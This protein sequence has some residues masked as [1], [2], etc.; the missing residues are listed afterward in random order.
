V[1]LHGQSAMRVRIYAAWFAG[2]LAVGIVLFAVIGPRLPTICPTCLLFH[3]VQDGLYIE[4]IKVGGN[5]ISYDNSAFKR[6]PDDRNV[7]KTIS[8]AQSKVKQFFGAREVDPRVFVC[9]TERCYITFERHRGLS[10]AI[11]FGDK[12]IFVSPRGINVTILSHELTHSEL[13]HRLGVFMKLVPTWFDEGL[14]VYV[15]D[16]RRYIAAPDQKDR[17]LVHTNRAMPEMPSGWWDE[18]E[19]RKELY[20]EAAC[21]VSEWIAAHHGS[22]AVTKLIAAMHAGASFRQAFGARN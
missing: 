14:A 9:V 13:H 15:S 3:K 17:C 2:S 20:S 11:S 8:V 22:V 5:E 4:G 7:E 6:A 19:H 10:K 18:E 1:L 12:Y 16:D 21:A